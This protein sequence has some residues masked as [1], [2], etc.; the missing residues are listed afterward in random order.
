MEVKPEEYRKIIPPLPT[1][2]I[3]T[4]YDEVKNVAPY[5]MN[6]P[7]SFNPPLYAIGVGLTKDTYKNILETKEFVVGIP[8]PD[9]VK[10]IDIA[11]KS[12]PRD[13][14]EFEKAGLT[15]LESK[16]VRPFRV[17]ECQSN[18][19]CKLEWIKQAGDHYIIVG[20]VVAASIDDKIYTK[21]LSRL[22]INPVYHVGAKEGEYAGKGKIIG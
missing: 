5:G 3:S 1:V 17:K 15:P 7:I 8:G 21:D 4:L 19:E 14:S 16:V 12:F 9:L 10:E 22:L 18:F 2:L 20:R 13:V 11:A 6:M